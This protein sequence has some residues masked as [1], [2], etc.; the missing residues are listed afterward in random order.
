[1][2]LLVAWLLG[3][4]GLAALTAGC[5]LLAERAAGIRLPGAL[6]VPTGLAGVIVVAGFFT[7]AR[8]TAV[9]AT[10]AVVVAAVAGLVL[11]C[12]AGR[13]RPAGEASW[14]PAAPP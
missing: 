5:G 11:A 8:F 12:R 3:P 7:V 10:P 9:L 13:L 1:M 2:T 4:L 6:V 14:R